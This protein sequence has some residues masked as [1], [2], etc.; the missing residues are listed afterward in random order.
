LLRERRHSDPLLVFATAASRAD[1][2][3]AVEPGWPVLYINPTPQ[4]TMLLLLD[5]TETGI[6]E[7]LR[8][9]NAPTSSG[10]FARLMMGSTTGALDETIG[11]SRAL[12]LIA[13]GVGDA[14]HMDITPA[15]DYALP[16]LGDALMRPAYEMLSEQG[17]EGVSLIVSGNLA[18]APLHAA[19]FGPAGQCL[20]DKLDVRYAPSAVVLDVSLKR[21]A[22]P[23]SKQA[24]LVALADPERD[25]PGG[26]LPPPRP[27]SPKSPETSTAPTSTKPP[28]AERTA[29]FSHGTLR[30]PTTCTSPATPLAACSTRARRRSRSPTVRSARSS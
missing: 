27:R 28:V 19:P 11:V 23:E 30:T 4:G 9:L 15:L 6:S 26:H 12:L 21:A 18:G 8:I 13:A 2:E 14:A 7:H 5:K 24:N 3:R 16:W 29:S 1:L 22:R 10:V 17:G 25:V 20:I